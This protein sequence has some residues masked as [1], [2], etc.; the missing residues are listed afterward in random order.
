M[1]LADFYNTLPTVGEN[2]MDCWIRLNKAVDMAEECLKRQGRNLEYPS[3]EVTMMFFKHC[4]DPALSAVL[5]FKTADKWKA[6]EIQERLDDHQTQLK[7]QQQRTRSKRSGAERYASANVQAAAIDESAL[8]GASMRPQTQTEVV[9]D[10]GTSPDNVSLQNLIDQ[11]DRVLKQN[12]QA[13]VQTPYM[14]SGFQSF[15]KPC[16]VC[17]ATDHS[18]TM[19]CRR[20]GLCLS[21]FKTGH[22]KRECRKAGSGASGP[23]MRSSQG[24]PLLN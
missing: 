23:G 20:D 24:Q 15:K 16:K 13:A 18:T 6:S 21:C 9:V 22:W 3:K 2:V 17:R 7:I 11:L 10:I 1:P 14:S 8:L 4:P 19:H 12:H 5:K